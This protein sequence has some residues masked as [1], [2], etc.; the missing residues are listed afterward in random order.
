MTQSMQVGDYYTWT[1]FSFGHYYTWT[2]FNDTKTCDDKGSAYE[3]KDPMSPQMFETLVALY[4]F[5]FR[6]RVN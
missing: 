6:H 5:H 3:T 4:P 1:W 2:I